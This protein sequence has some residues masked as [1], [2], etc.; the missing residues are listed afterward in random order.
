MDIENVFF[1]NYL[2]L[3]QFNLREQF[4]AYDLLR[5]DWGFK[6]SVPHLFLLVFIVFTDKHRISLTA[7]QLSH[8]VLQLL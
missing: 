4:L 3:Y 1:M 8:L 5:L 6:I 7:R 2:T